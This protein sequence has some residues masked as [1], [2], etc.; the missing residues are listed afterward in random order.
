MTTDPVSAVFAALA[1]PTRRAILARLAT[2]EA[3]VNELA[4][5]FPIS[6]QAI[7]KH[8]AVLERA[9]LIVRTR[10]A[11]WRRCRL[12]P[13]PLRTLAEWVDQYRRLWDDRYDT[14]DDYLRDLKETRH[15]QSP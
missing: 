6:L 7:S 13:A 1:D 3:T 15:E 8:L 5:P 4:A 2:G 14:L 10:E 12:D 9:G 11:Q